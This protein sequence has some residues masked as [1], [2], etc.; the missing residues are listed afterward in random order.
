MPDCTLSQAAP[1]RIFN[2]LSGPNGSATV[3]AIYDISWQLLWQGD[4]LMIYEEAAHLVDR[5][6]ERGKR[7]MASLHSEAVRARGH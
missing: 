1:A 6:S 3:V 7:N 5:M 4:P 2:D